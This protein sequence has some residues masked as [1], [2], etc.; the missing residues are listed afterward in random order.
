MGASLTGPV[1]LARALEARDR[2]LGEAARALTEL[3]AETRSIR[4]RVEETVHF[5]SRA[6]GERERLGAAIADAETLLAAKQAAEGAAVERLAQAEEGRSDDELRAARTSLVAARDAAASARRR[7]DELRGAASDLEEQIGAAE[8]ESA[9]VVDDAVAA[10]TALRATRRVAVGDPEPGLDGVAAWA[11]AARS[12]SFVAR[13]ALQR[14]REAVYREAS[15][16]ASSVLGE[17]T[18]AAS[19]ALVRERLERLAGR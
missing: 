14:Q 12:A 11:A 16:L 5:L 6:P 7:R 13:G 10:A 9:A 3:E 1:E 19:A 8:A 18:Y 4:T 17:P 2:D 15:E